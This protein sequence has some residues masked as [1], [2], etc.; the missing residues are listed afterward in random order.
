[1]IDPWLERQATGCFCR[2][3]EDGEVRVAITAVMR[4]T[5]KTQADEMFDGVMT[6]PV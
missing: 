5:W 1:M 3:L 4:R 2:R 6:R